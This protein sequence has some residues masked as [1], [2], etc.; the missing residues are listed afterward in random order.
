MP[1]IETGTAILFGM[2]CAIITLVL[3]LA[4]LADWIIRLQHA[5]NEES[6][7]THA[8]CV[9]HI[10]DMVSDRWAAVVLRDLADRYEGGSET[11]VLNKIKREVWT[12]EGPVLPV[13]W[14]RHHADLLDAEAARIA[15]E[16]DRENWEDGS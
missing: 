16:M 5:L 14:L 2:A 9:A 13:L 3:V 4:L 15:A 11:L 12:P 7:S 1:E 6:D 8:I 10:A